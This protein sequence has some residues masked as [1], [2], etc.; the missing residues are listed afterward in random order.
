MH[1]LDIIQVRK[2]HDFDSISRDDISLYFTQ[3]QNFPG[4]AHRVTYSMVAPLNFSST[5]LL[6]SYDTVIRQQYI[7][8]S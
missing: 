4:C 2:E 7:L 5:L 6:L 1:T 3:P 8:S